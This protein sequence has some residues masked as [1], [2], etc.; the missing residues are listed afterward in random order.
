MTAEASATASPVLYVIVCGSPAARTVYG[1][2]GQAKAQGWRV[3]VV[4][5]PMGANF[6]DCGRLDAAT[7]FP[8]RTEFKNPEDPDVLPQADAFVVAPA[9]FNTVNKLAAGIGDTLALAL[10][11][12]GIGYRRPV[13]LVPWFNSGLA[14]NGAYAR[15]LTIL[16]SEGVRI[17]HATAVQDELFPWDALLV[18]LREVLKGLA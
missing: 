14:N 5:T 18:E 12:E 9:T 7:G 2:I 13:F 15:S 11:C 10:L 17:L 6:V 8:V 1:F 16:R 3:C 4:P